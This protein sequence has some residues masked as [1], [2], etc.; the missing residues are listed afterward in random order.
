MLSRAPILKSNLLLLSL[1]AG[2]AGDVS[3]PTPNA[4]GFVTPGTELPSAGTPISEQ[5]APATPMAGSDPVVALPGSGG[6]TASMAPMGV[7][8]MPGTPTVPGPAPTQPTVAPAACTDGRLLPARIWRLNDRQF[9]NAA[10]DLLPG[11]KVPNISTAGR[12]DH[13]FISVEGR[14]RIDDGFTSQLQGVVETIA[15]QASQQAETITGCAG[16][17][18]GCVR[19]FAHGL[20]TRAYRRPLTGAETTAVDE[21]LAVGANPAESFSLV[22]EG[23]LQSPSFLYRWELGDPNAP[24]GPSRLT[25]YELASS[26]SFF[27]LD[28]I[29]DEELTA[30]AASGEL[31]T[32]AGLTAQVERLMAEDKVQHH[33]TELFMSWLEL[34]TVMTIEKDQN[35]IDFEF[36]NEARQSI[37]DEARSFVHNILWTGGSLADLLTSRQTWATGVAAEIL[38]VPESDGQ[39]RE[40]PAAER[41]G[42]LTRPALAAAA[43]SGHNQVVYRGR[44][45]REVFLCGIVPEPPASLDTEAINAGLEGATERERMDQRSADP[46]CAGCHGFMDPLGISMEVFGHVGELIPNQPD[47]A[48]ELTLTDVNGPFTSIV[49]LSA[50]LAQSTTVRECVA[51]QMASYALGQFLNTANDS[52][53][54]R[55]IASTISSPTSPLRDV[56][57]G[58]ALNSSFTNRLQGAAQ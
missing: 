35:V 43:Q 11:I 25:G 37:F 14:Y 16:L 7:P 45:L 26:L 33:L 9:Q 20:A 55:Q 34:P 54:T 49:D 29:P 18:A 3:G 31:D 57:K 13:E 5:P 46:S 44:L 50:R 17:E 21:L 22:V 4:T 41:A 1:A 2:C 48:G 23:V 27:F 8:A 56:F 42:L 10:G 52:C 53:T 6:A 38:G 36:N 12:D 39:P 28:S 40:L 32:E 51:E 24:A 30:A 19:Q 58:I 15:A 47:A